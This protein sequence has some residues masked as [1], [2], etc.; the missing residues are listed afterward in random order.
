[1][2]IHKRQRRYEIEVSGWRYTR[3]LLVG[4]RRGE[5]WIG[6]RR[7]FQAD[8]WEIAVFGL[9][10]CVPD[11]KKPRKGQDEGIGRGVAA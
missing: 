2:K 3:R 5:W 9:T 1:M 10:V 7:N 11:E 4:F 6:W 8:W